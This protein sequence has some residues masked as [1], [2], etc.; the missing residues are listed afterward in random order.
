MIYKKDANF[1]YPILS[2]GSQSYKNNYFIFDVTLEE[3]T[4]MYRFKFTYDIG[5]KFIEKLIENEDAV[6]IFIIQSKDNKFYKL[7][8]CQNSIDIN[9]DRLSL[10]KNRTSIQL[11]IQSNKEIGFSDNKDLSPFYHAFKDEIAV[12]PHSLL[13]FSNIV[14]LEGRMQNPLHLFDKKLDENLNSDIKIELGSEAIVINYRKPEFQFAGMTNKAFNNPYIYSGLRTALL[15]FIKD[16]GGDEDYVDL[17]QITQPDNLLDFK[18]YQ[19]MTAKMVE[20]VS[21]DS[22]DEVIYKISDRI[23]EKYAVA[24]KELVSN[25]D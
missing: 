25:G 15:R 2:N 21:A 18:L 12:P 11:H 7:G 24:V 19:L 16:Y 13:G 1:S 8:P 4:D 22:I 6:M 23:I 14:A 9:K 10:I 20:E 3:D 5:S 17:T